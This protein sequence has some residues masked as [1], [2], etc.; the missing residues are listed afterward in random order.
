MELSGLTSATWATEMA[1]MGADPEA[2]RRDIQELVGARG[3][4]E[5]RVAL[6]RASQAF[7]AVFV[8]Q[9]ISAMRQTVGDGGLI[10]KSNGEKIFESMLDEEWAK[11]LVSRS[12]SGSI[13]E[14]LYRQL[15]QDMGLDAGDQAAPPPQTG[16]VVELL[17][18]GVPA[19]AVLGRGRSAR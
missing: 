9:M 8:R 5:K 10:K 18:G 7:E 13:S 2:Q 15:S 14:M 19:A 16:S 11:K 3:P 1:A 12:G 6:R 17:Q 4:E